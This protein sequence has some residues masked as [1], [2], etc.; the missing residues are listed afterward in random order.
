MTTREDVLAIVASA[1]AA[2]VDLFD[3]APAYGR[4]E[5]VLGETLPSGFGRVVTKTPNFPNAKLGT[6]EIAHGLETFDASLRQLKREAVYGLLVHGA[7]DLLKPGGERLF[8][9]L[10]RLREQ[11]R[12]AKIG[13]S[14]YTPAQVDG[15]LERYAI[16]LIQVPLNVFDQRLIVGGQLARLKQSGVEVHARSALLQGLLT[17]EPSLCPPYFAPFIPLLQ[18]FHALTGRLGLSPLRAALGF[19]LSQSE[20]DFAVCGVNTPAQ[21][22][23]LLQAAVV[24]LDSSSFGE[25]IC[26]DL[27][28]LDP[29]RWK[30][31][32]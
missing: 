24:N 4:S 29:S 15:I 27:N 7:D 18:R 20:V 3:T 17:M 28:L 12:V 23:E 25:L 26:D 5:A 16:D 9:A 1:A 2:K 32:G 6:C 14:V 13:V 30:L 10:E 8:A 11:G 22:Q 19:V 31:N 21:W